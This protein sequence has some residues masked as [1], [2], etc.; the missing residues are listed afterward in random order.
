MLIIIY[1]NN[2]KITG[3]NRYIVEC[4]FV[5]EGKTKEAKEAF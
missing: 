1:T 3:F 4:K 2:I 5:N